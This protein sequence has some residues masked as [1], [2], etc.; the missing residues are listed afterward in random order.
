MQCQR[1]FE[2]F[3]SGNLSVNDSSHSSRS[4]EI[5]TEKIKVLL[6]ENPY[7]AARYITDDLEISHTRVLNHIHRISYVIM[8]LCQLYRYARLDRGPAGATDRC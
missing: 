4:N 5:D 1:W 3:R 6:D 8:S 7:L 2:K